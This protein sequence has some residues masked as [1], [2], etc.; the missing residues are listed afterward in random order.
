MNVEQRAAIEGAVDQ[1][2]TFA[3]VIAR[4]LDGADT[5]EDW[6]L[7]HHPKHR[8]VSPNDLDAIQYLADGIQKQGEAVMKAVYGD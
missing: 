7:E 2:Q 3:H 6:N 5:G 1:I 4:L 8:I